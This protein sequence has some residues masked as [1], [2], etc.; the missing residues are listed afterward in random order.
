M[1]FICINTS[2]FSVFNFIVKLR[3]LDIHLKSNSASLFH[4]L[5]IHYQVLVLFEGE[6]KF[7]TIHSK[8]LVS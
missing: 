8:V 4:F 1:Q 7:I 6:M 5:C 2:I 3:F